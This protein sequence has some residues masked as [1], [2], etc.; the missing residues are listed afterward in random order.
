MRR[1]HCSPSSPR[2]PACSSTPWRSK[3]ASAPMASRR[4]SASASSAKMRA[5][6]V[7]LYTATGLLHDFDYERHPSPEEHP[8]VGVRVL[9][10]RGW[11]AEIRH[12][13]PRPRR[14]LRRT[15]RITHLDKAL[16]ACDELAGFL[17]AC[18][19]IK[20]TKAIARCRSRRRA[21]E[22]ERQSL[23]PRR[24]PRRR[25]QRRDRTRNRSRRSTSPS[26]SRQCS[27]SG[28]V[29]ISWPPESISRVLLQCAHTIRREARSRSWPRPLCFLFL[30]A[31]MARSRPPRIA[32]RWKDS[33]ARLNHQ[34]IH[35]GVRRRILH[36]Q[37]VCDRSGARDRDVDWE[38]GMHI[39]DLGSM[40]VA[41]YRA[42]D[43]KQFYA[44]RVPSHTV[45]RRVLALSPSGERLAVLTDSTVRIY[46][47]KR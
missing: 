11:P 23:R 1:G 12:R 40:T 16:F 17:T 35:A 5:R 37:C 47:T 3:A 45:D 4:P 42:V 21:K 38:T 46:R 15:P 33:V 34:S 32:L 7:E 9:E 28:S 41:V 39:A 44:T 8:L 6:F 25:D 19:L 20:P 2:A 14:I 43:G 30:P 26:A 24:Q 18:A 29:R 13:H 22:D 10:Q 27:G 36:R 31:H